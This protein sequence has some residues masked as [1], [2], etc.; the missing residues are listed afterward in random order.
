MSNGQHVWRLAVG[1]VPRFGNHKN[2]HPSFFIVLGFIALA[3]VLG[4]VG[5]AKRKGKQ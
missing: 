1:V 3:I 4:L 2:G 5:R